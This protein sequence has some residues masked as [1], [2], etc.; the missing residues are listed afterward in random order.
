MFYFP[1]SDIGR[2]E[3]QCCK[4]N[5]KE[6]TLETSSSGFLQT[7][8]HINGSTPKVYGTVL[9]A[10][11]GEAI[12]G[13]E[14]TVNYM[15]DPHELVIEAESSS[16]NSSGYFEI[17]LKENN[18]YVKINRISFEK[19]GYLDK[20]ING[21]EQSQLSIDIGQIELYGEDSPNFPEAI[22]IST[23]EVL[24]K[25][26]KNPSADYIMN[27]RYCF[28]SVSTWEPIMNFEGTFDG[29]GYSN[30]KL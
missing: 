2:Y 5:L 17:P 24:K 11:T 10:D 27:K 13:V 23:I 30:F 16:T 22:P 7:V 4:I 25:I 9:D 28:A 12:E 29:N 15:P 6:V 20:H 14:V 19:P 21:S 26:R 8:Q 1:R 3:E 18:S